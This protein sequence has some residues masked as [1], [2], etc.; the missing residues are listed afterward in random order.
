[1]GLAISPLVVP[2]D[3][4]G[5][6]I[7]GHLIDD[8]DLSSPAGPIAASTFD[9]EADINQGTRVA[10]PVALTS[11]TVGTIAVGVFDA[12]DMTGAN[13]FQTVSGDDADYLCLTKDNVTEAN[14]PL[15]VT[16]DS[17]TPGL[18]VSPNGGD[19]E[20]TWSASGI[21]QI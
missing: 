21:I 18:P 15:I 14:A 9:S 13:S 4:D 11:L 2:V 1:M 5:D 12:A 8:T 6:T 7:E 16:Y 3:F 20:V 19:I 10:G 17:A